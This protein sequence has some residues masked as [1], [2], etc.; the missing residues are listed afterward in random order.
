MVT[1]RNNEDRPEK[2]VPLARGGLVPPALAGMLKQ[3]EERQ[4]AKRERERRTRLHSF[5]LAGGRR[6]PRG[7]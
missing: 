7:E 2:V 1:K 3:A 4:A 5:K 6:A